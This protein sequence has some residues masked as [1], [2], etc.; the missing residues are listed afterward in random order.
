MVEESF[1]KARMNQQPPMHQ[2]AILSI[3]WVVFFHLAPN[4]VH[5]NSF[6]FTTDHSTFYFYFFALRLFFPWT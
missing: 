6:F 2:L 4:G 5:H 1:L 3:G